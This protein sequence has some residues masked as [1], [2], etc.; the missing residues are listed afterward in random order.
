MSDPNLPLAHTN[1]PYL[2]DCYRKLLTSAKLC[3]ETE[4]IENSREYEEKASRIILGF[5]LFHTV[6]VPYLS[7]YLNSLMAMLKLSIR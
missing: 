7:H 3:Q 5:F 4:V 6:H 2:A 1:L